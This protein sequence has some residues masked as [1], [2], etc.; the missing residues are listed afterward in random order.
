VIPYT[1]SV[2]PKR[3]KLRNDS[4]LP[5]CRKSRTESIEPKRVIPVT[6]SDEARREK[7]RNDKVLPRWRKSSTATALPIR[8]KLRNA[9]E[10]PK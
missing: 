3:P 8:A 6:E 2:E 4:E 9:I 5:R 10:L 7:E 1:L